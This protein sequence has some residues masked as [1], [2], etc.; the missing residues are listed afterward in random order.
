MNIV[1]VTASAPYGSGESFILN[2]IDA[3]QQLGHTVTVI[4]LRPKKQCYVSGYDVLPARLLSLKTLGLSLLVWLAHFLRICKVAWPMLRRAGSLANM[5]KNLIVIPKALAV[6][7][8]LQASKVDVIHSHWLS[9]PTTMAYIMSG[10]MRVPF[11]ATA[12]RWDIYNK[13][14]LIA[15]AEKLT[16]M[17]VIS[18]RGVND[19]LAMLPRELHK[20]VH[21]LH[22]GVD[23]PDVSAQGRCNKQVFNIAVVANMIRQKGHVYALEAQKKIKDSGNEDIILHFYGSGEEEENLHNIVAKWGLQQMVIFHGQVPHAD[24]LAQYKS[25]EIDCVV[26]ASFEEDGLAFEGIPVSLLE[27]MAYKIP[28]IATDSGSIPE[29]LDEGAGVLIPQKNADALTEAIMEIRDHKVYA[30]NVA[31]KGRDRVKTDFNNKII[32]VELAQMLAA[33]MKEV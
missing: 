31:Q 15:K 8:Y 29:L 18:Q 14:A 13:N 2:E 20:K 33:A 17:R 9:T 26:L 24:L 28:V 4:P 21:L 19:V 32:S 11:I 10:I 25:R 27:A 23:V 12:H 7:H 6:T 22:M 5:L 16:A 3:L 30:Q 1:Y